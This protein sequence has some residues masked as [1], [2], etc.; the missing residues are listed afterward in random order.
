[1]KKAWRYIL[2]LFVLVLFF[3]TK[4]N[5]QSCTANTPS[6]IVDLTGGPD[7]AWFSPHESRRGICCGYNPGP[8]D[9][10]RCVEF[11]L[12][13][14]EGAQGIR[15]EIAR[16]AEPRGA[17]GWSLNC[18]PLN[19]VGE[20]ICLDGTGPHWITF[21]KP[22]NN[23]NTYSIVS[24]PRPS[25]SPPVLVSDGCNAELSTSGFQQNTIQ[26]TSVPFNATHNSY[27]SCTSGCPTVTANYAVGAPD[28]VQ[29]QVSGIPIAGCSEEPVTLTTWVHFVNDKEVV[30]VP[31]DPVICFGGTEAEITAHATGG[32]PPYQYVWSTGEN[33]QSIT[34][35]VGTYSVIV[36]DDTS[37]PPASTE[38]T[39]TAFDSPII[40]DAGP[41]L[42]TCENNPNTEINAS[43]HQADGGTWTGGN[44][45]FIPDRNSLSIIYEPTQA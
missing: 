42:I 35:G 1:M 26:W 16:G 23:P 40:A 5:G 44:G 38:V 41:D 15:F 8:P 29:Y 21:C 19:P 36:L 11:W 25:V 14:D 12:T 13:L 17:L 33:T 20:D 30:I 2:L 3:E 18:G 6:H 28:S 7:S 37:C 10:Y 43:V 34:V 31:Q 32:R 39:V 9:N 27:L 4:T 45:N 24:I 22:G